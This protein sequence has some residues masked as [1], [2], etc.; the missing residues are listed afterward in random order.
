[1]PDGSFYRHASEQS[2]GVRIFMDD[3]TTFSE[4][5]FPILV[6]YLILVAVLIA[7]NGV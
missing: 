3:D 7:K 2:K 4:I 1:M 5:A 6:T